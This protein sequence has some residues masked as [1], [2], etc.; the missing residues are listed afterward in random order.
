[1]DADLEERGFELTDFSSLGIQ[2]MVD[3][4]IDGAQTVFDYIREGPTWVLERHCENLEFERPIDKHCNY[5]DSTKLG[6]WCKL[7]LYWREGESSYEEEIKVNTEEYEFPHFSKDLA[8][9]LVCFSKMS[10]DKNDGP[11]FVLQSILLRD[12]SFPPSSESYFWDSL[13]LQQEAMGYTIEVPF[14]KDSPPKVIAEFWNLEIS[15]TDD[16]REWI[17]GGSERYALVITGPNH[18]LSEIDTLLRA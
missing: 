7:M 11:A 2:K 8:S 13:E 15:G 9:G 16:H 14:R 6:H 5:C 1:M 10:I 18:M 12:L 4:D 3:G 17:L